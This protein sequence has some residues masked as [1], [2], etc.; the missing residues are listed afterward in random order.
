M[1]NAPRG[2]D[3]NGRGCLRVIALPVRPGK[4]A[5][6]YHTRDRAPARTPHGPPLP[7]SAPFL[8]ALRI[9]IPSPRPDSIRPPRVA[10]RP[11]PVPS[12]VAGEPARRP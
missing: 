2:S 10:P 8:P 7:L 6:K 4:H 12:H 11:L 1:A 5:A 3:G 9:V